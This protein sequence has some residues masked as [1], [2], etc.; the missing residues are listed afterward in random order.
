MRTETFKWMLVIIS[1]T[2]LIYHVF[3]LFSLWSEI[4]NTI[5]IHFSKGKPD[6]WGS[7]YFLFIMPAV[8]LV[9]W[10]LIGLVVKK[11]EKLNY[12][13][14]TEENRQLQYV[15]AE[16]GMVVIQYLGSL[17]FVCANEA[18]LRNAVGMESSLPYSIAI[19]LL[20]ICFFVPIYH[21]FWAAMLKY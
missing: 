1:I 17:V 2:I 6:H 15:K 4:P 11:P 5:P 7:R 13:N 8:S 18:T 10:F 12:V 19:M 3:H 9:I 21:L 20:A 14:L 16:K